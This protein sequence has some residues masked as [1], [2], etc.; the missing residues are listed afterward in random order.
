VN[1]S[2]LPVSFFVRNYGVV[3][4]GVRPVP[5]DVISVLQE[6]SVVDFFVRPADVSTHRFQVNVAAGAAHHCHETVTINT[7]DFEEL[8]ITT[9]QRTFGT[10][11]P[12]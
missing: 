11:A 4:Y 1:N 8:S 6:R 9:A 2:H 10:T 7:L 3:P 5:A 12:Q